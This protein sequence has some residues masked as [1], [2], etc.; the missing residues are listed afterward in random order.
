MKR[1]IIAISR[2]HGAGGGAVGKKL[3]LA[4]G[5][6]AYE[7]TVIELAA[8]K[9]G[10]S[11]E[12]V[13]A[14]EETASRSFL[15]N[16]VS[17]TYSAH[18]MLPQY[19]VPVTFSAY[20]AQG[21]VIRELAAR[22]SSVIIGRC[23]EYVLREDPDCVKV[24]L[25]AN[26]EDRIAAVM[27]ESD[28]SESDAERRLRQIDR[29]RANYYRGFTGE[30]WGAMEHHDLCINTSTTGIDGAVSAIIAALRA[31]GRLD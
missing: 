31:M 4:L 17:T 23:A 3:G 6:P 15:F 30:K 8:E 9:S 18:N 25:R 7:R 5:I 13:N 24:F 2:E 12:Y 22:G 11:A 20:A 27:R 1:T 29:G 10:L 28:L 21:E 19:N 16:I 14:L 26:R